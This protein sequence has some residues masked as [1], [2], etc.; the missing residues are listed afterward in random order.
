MKGPAGSSAGAAAQNPPFPLPRPQGKIM[1]F[2]SGHGPGF[3]GS[4]NMKRKFSNTVLLAMAVV[5][6]G[7]GPAPRA[8]EESSKQLSETVRAKISEN[9]G[10]GHVDDIK[11]IRIDER[12][13]YVVE[14]D[15]P[16]P[17]ERKLHVTGEGVLL[18]IVDRL[19]LPDLPPAVRATVDSIQASKGRFDRADKVT[20][21]GKVEYHLEFDLPGRVELELILSETGEVI[22]RREEGNL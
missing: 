4:G 18:K 15:L 16:G 17:R 21:N 6:T 7:L 10:G 14:I 8:G 1:F 9:L 5:S 22:S 12:Q 19:R 13:L 11:V 3:S 2:R 20:A